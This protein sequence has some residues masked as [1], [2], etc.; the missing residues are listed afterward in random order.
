MTKCNHA[1]GF[2]KMSKKVYHLSLVADSDDNDDTDDAIQLTKHVGKRR[3]FFFAAFCVAV[4]MILLILI[5]VSLALYS[6]FK[7]N[8]TK[9]SD[10]IAPDV[11]NSKLLDYID[12][13]F[14]PCTDF[15]NYSCGNWLSANPLNDRSIR[16]TFYSLSLD[17]YDHLMGYLSQPVRESDPTAIKKTKYMYSACKNVDFIGI[18]L[19]DHLREFIGSAGGWDSIEIMPD[20][21]WDIND[22]LVV[23]HY[24]GSSAFFGIGVAPD[25]LNSSKPVIKVSTC[26]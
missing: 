8:N 20:N 11:C 5:G 22:D 24:L 15:Y 25:D 1:F 26:S 12:D 2:A 4:I 16:G 9:N 6:V 10:C 23:H 14:D 19:V 21:G 13:R 17:N 3:L 18:N 7:K